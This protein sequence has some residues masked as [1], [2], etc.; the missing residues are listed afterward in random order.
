MNTPLTKSLAATLLVLFLFP[1]SAFAEMKALLPEK[2]LWSVVHDKPAV[3]NWTTTTYPLPKDKKVRGAVDTEDGTWLNGKKYVFMTT[4]LILPEDYEPGNLFAQYVHDDSVQIAV[5]GT[6]VIQSSGGGARWDNGVKIVYTKR[7]PNLLKPG[8]NIIAAFCENYGGSG[9]ISVALAA[10][11]EP[12]VNDIPLFALNGQWSVTFDN[13]GENW[14][15]K[16]PLPGGKKGIAP[17]STNLN[18]GWPGNKKGIWMTRVVTLPKDYKPGSLHAEF[19]CLEKMWLYIN[20]KEVLYQKSTKTWVSRKNITNPLKPGE[21]V[22]AVYCERWNNNAG[23]VGLDLWL[24]EEKKGDDSEFSMPTRLPRDVDDEDDE[25]P[26]E[27]LTETEKLIVSGMKLL[28]EGKEKPAVEALVAAA[29]TD[30]ADFQANCILGMFYL[31]K[32]YKP[33]IAMEYMQACVKIDAQSP[34]VLNNYAVAAVETKKYA[35]ALKAWQ[36]LAK[37]YPT[38]AELRQNIGFLTELTDNNMVKLKDDER[39]R[40]ETLFREVCGAANVKTDKTAGFLLM[41]LYEGVG[42]DPNFA[43][44]FVQSFKRGREN[45]TGNPYEVKRTYFQK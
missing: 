42:A 13:P 3:K 30:K 22:I 4:E 5:N 28:K 37:N 26:G 33:L 40:L 41:P 6:M 25:E 20:G 7:V 32:N 12:Y 27:D 24:G 1:A 19:F 9:H 44:I 14:T 8:K 2:S 29:K 18:G 31:T 38:L 15:M 16:S 23:Y 43:E 36:R 35:D 39:Q 11:D 45:V 34:I 17:F 21:N 10:N